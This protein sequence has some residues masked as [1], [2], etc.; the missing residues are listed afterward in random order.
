ME[1][2]GIVVTYGAL[3]QTTTGQKLTDE[4]D[5]N[6]NQPSSSL[7]SATRFKLQRDLYWQARQ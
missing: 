6:R 3:G 4:P 2:G 1:T 7:V 5:C